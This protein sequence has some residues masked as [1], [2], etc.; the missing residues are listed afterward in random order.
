[1]RLI[2]LYNMKEYF[3][4]YKIAGI[5]EKLVGKMFMEYENILTPFKFYHDQ[6]AHC[7]N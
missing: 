7:M 3:S 5:S 4:K 2:Q 6:G 1:M